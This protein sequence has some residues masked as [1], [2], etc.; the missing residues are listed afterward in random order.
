MQGTCFAARRSRIHPSVSTS[1]GDGVADG[2][3]D[4]VVGCVLTEIG[5]GMAE[6][7]CGWT[8]SEPAAER[9]F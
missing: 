5:T 2:K 7:A 8:G 9:M 4:A 3:A 1:S 6:T